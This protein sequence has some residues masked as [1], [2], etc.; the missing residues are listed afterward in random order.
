MAFELISQRNS[1]QTCRVDMDL[2]LEHLETKH[3]HFSEG[4]LH[5]LKSCAALSC[6]N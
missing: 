3:W 4:E 5:Y 2:A 1:G 6:F